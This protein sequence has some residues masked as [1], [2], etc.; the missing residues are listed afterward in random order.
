VLVPAQPVQDKQAV[1]AAIDRVRAWGGTKLSEGLRGG[2]QEV[3]TYL[4]PDVVS[5]MVV[6][7]DGRTSGDEAA[8]REIAD[9]A[10]AWGVGISPLGLG[11]NWDET[12]LDEL[13]QR[14]GGMP[15]QW[16]QGPAEMGHLFQEQARSAA[17]AVRHTTL[18]LRLPPGVTAQRAVRMLPIVDDLGDAV[19]ERLEVVV[20]LGDLPGETTQAV[21]FEIMIEPHRPGRYRVAQVEVTYD[22]PLLGLMKQSA[23]Q[24]LLVEFVSDPAQATPV[25]ETVMAYA[26]R[27]NAYR[28]VNRA[29]DEYRRT[30]RTTIGMD[31][32]ITSLLDDLTRAQL[33]Q[34]MAGQVTPEQASVL[35]KGITMRMR[36]TT[37]H[38]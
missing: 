22:V 30:G 11:A 12:L 26:R 20:S 32:Q 33:D 29:L 10:R 35:M 18:A 15:A 3:S 17:V 28:L 37:E 23:R 36:H 19:Q 27:A 2:L 6:L 31:G 14:S 7:T 1:K 21:L 13:G 38:P 34:L 24:D 5:R 16:V 8:C 4:R 9:Q 25:D